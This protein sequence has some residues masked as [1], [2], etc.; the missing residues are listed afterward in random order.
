MNAT[1]FYIDSFTD[2]LMKTID[3][4][5]RVQETEMTHKDLVTETR[6]LFLC[7]RVH[8]LEWLKQQFSRPSYEQ[9]L[10]QI[11]KNAR[12]LR[13]NVP[14]V[15]NLCT[16]GLL[17]GEFL[18]SVICDSV[19]LSEEMRNRLINEYG[20]NMYRT[21]VFKWRGREE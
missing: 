12:I 2:I 6:K 5:E 1:N 21:V 16:C 7:P 14:H 10:E 3:L 8:Y 11:Q 15:S 20:L 18:F 9:S 4:Y 13:D 17:I 19:T